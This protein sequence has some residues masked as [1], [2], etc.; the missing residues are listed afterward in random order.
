MPLCTIS[1]KSVL[2]ELFRMISR[3]R[4][5]KEILTDQETAFMS[6]TLSK[7]YEIIA[8]ESIRTSIY[9]PKMDGLV[10]QFKKLGKN[11]DK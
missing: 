1:A 4:I 9:H 3:V 2:D 10:E 5:P 7:L 11:W 6:S 8:I